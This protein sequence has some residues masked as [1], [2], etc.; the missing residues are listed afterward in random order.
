M[1]DVNVGTSY[2]MGVWRVRI[3]FG[4]ELSTFTLLP[5]GSSA[6]KRR[7]ASKTKILPISFTKL[8]NHALAHSRRMVSQNLSGSLRFLA[9]YNRE[10][11]LLVLYVVSRIGLIC[12]S[13]M[14]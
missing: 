13:H 11:G 5:S 12:S 2:A 3:F 8:P 14:V 6:T 9:Y 7:S 4:F 1:S 10:H